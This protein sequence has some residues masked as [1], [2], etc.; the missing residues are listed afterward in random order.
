MSFSPGIPVPNASAQ[1]C[2]PPPV[3]HFVGRN[4]ECIMAVNHMTSTSSRIF[5]IWGSRGFGKT[6]TAIAIANKLKS[7]GHCICYFSFRGVT[8]L[9]NFIS[10][11]LGFFSPLE[12]V[13]QLAGIERLIRVFQ[14]T[15]TR[16]F[17]VLDNLDDL[18][19]QTS[20]EENGSSVSENVL[21]FIQEVIG[22]C[23]NI[24]LLTTTRNS[25]HG[26]SVEIGGFESVKLGP[27]DQEASLDL[28]SQFLPDET[29]HIKHQISE[30]CGNVPI[31]MRRLCGLISASGENAMEI[32]DE[33]RTSS[34]NWLDII[35]DEI[36]I[37]PKV[38][39]EQVKRSFERLSEAEKNRVVKLRAFSG[40]DFNIDVAAYVMNE[41]KIQT[42]KTLQILESNALIEFNKESKVY[43]LHPLFQ[44]FISDVLEKYEIPVY[45]AVMRLHEYYNNLFDTL[46]TRFL[47]EESMSAFE[48]FFKEEGD[49]YANFLAV[50]NFGELFQDGKMQHLPAVFEE[51]LAVL[52]RSELL[53][54]SL[55]SHNVLKAMLL[56]KRALEEAKRCKKTEAYRK[57]LI[58]Q[59]FYITHQFIFDNLEN[60]ILQD[61]EAVEALSNEEKAKYMCYQ[62]IYAI[63]RKE[64]PARDMEVKNLEL[65]LSLL[66]HSRPDHLMVRIMGLQIL[67]AFYRKRCN[68]ARYNEMYGKAQDACQ[69]HGKDNIFLIP[70]VDN[71]CVPTNN[72]E[73]VNVPQIVWVASR[74]C[75]WTYNQCRWPEM[76][77][78]FFQLI[79]PINDRLESTDPP[80][81]ERKM[82]Q[83]CNVTLQELGLHATSCGAVDN[84]HYDIIRTSLDSHP[85]QRL[86]DGIRP[87]TQLSRN[88]NLPWDFIP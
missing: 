32:L 45:L 26:S 42:R 33:I 62:G 18:L 3:P 12:R 88:R 5:S 21:N 40:A 67:T 46:N 61:D 53:L 31:A 10:K 63:T 23:D 82:R 6:S 78:K 57:L 9:E 48:T 17:V 20:Q 47:N 76:D 4:E 52:G 56:Y 34:K 73:S 39:L 16:R 30:I 25:L 22:R 19:S 41:S 11:L 15:N 87:W 49:I 80:K 55:Y 43:S 72:D 1:S 58:S 64:P 83:L 68:D 36:D 27:L 8:T 38:S 37:S 44:T 28:I 54:F 35:R 66:K 81:S 51:V 71:T 75:E 7:E 86:E 24:V 69:R 70:P 79:N 65:G 84:T 60:Y 2:V 13:P 77:R 59:Q 50:L 74:L 85:H 29:S 14:S